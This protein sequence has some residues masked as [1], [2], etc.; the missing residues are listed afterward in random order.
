VLTAAAYW[1]AHGSSVLMYS[2]QVDSSVLIHAHGSSMVI[3]AWQPSYATM[4][5]R[6]VN[7]SRRQRWQ[8]KME[9]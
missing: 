5:F 6:R 9:A 4:I 7:G 8:R 3:Y 2:R 1:Y